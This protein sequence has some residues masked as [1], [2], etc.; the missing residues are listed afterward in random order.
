MS[1]NFCDIFDHGMDLE[2]RNFVRVFLVLVANYGKSRIEKEEKNISWICHQIHII[3]VFF[4]G[5]VGYV[6]IMVSFVIMIRNSLIQMQVINN[7]YIFVHPH[8]PVKYHCT[9]TWVDISSV[10]RMIGVLVH[11]NI[12]ASALVVFWYFSGTVRYAGIVMGG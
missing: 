5:G 10:R 2:L 9:Y 7:L 11:R 8:L 3:F 6:S 1:D 12:R 4:L